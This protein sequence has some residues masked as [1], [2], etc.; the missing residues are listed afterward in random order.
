[1]LLLL[2]RLEI[3]KYKLL[4]SYLLSVSNGFFFFTQQNLQRHLGVSPISKENKSIMIF[5][6]FKYFMIS[7]WFCVHF[8]YMKKIQFIGCLKRVWFSAKIGFRNAFNDCSIHIVCCCGYTYIAFL[9]RVIDD[10]FLF[11]GM[12]FGKILLHNLNSAV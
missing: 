12:A 10:I 3:D 7:S 8:Y 5:N 11:C 4:F 1:M 2:K 6:S 9:C